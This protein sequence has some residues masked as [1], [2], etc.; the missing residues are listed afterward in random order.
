MYAEIAPF[1]DALASRDAGADGAF[2]YAVKTTGVY[3]RPSCG[4]RTP[5]PENIAYYPTAQAAEAAGFRPCKRCQPNMPPREEVMAAKIAAACRRIEAAE[6]PPGLN[7]LAEKAGISPFHF[8][9]IFKSV[10]GVTPKAYAAAHRAKIL[11]SALRAAPRVTDAIY[12]AGYNAPA[13][14][15]AAAPATLGMTPKNFRAGGAG[16]AIVYATGD[17]RFGAILAAASATGICAISLGDDA[18]T[19]IRDLARNFS[20]ASIAPADAAFAQSLETI[21]AFIEQPGANLDLPLD[22]RGTAFQRRVWQALRAIPAGRTVS[23]AELGA[24]LGAG[25]SARA[26]ASACAANTLAVAIPCHRARR[27]TGALAG[28]RW[29]I[30]RKRALLAREADV[31]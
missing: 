7:T 1:F 18:Q 19:L 25:K 27:A 28:Y 23:Y 5:R 26:V 29:G 8:H 2:F 21:I 3:C 4:A 10:T 15:Y 17:C 6:T 31:S 20:R 22:I 24:C 30:A 11:Q 16:E 12:E 13:P 14:F 9:K